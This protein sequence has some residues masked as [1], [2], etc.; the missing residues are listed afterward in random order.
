[1]LNGSEVGEGA[2]VGAGAIVTPRTK[3]PPFTMV[4]GVPAKVV[5]NLSE[6]EIENLKKHA[7]DY[8]ELMKKYK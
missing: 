4:L 6:E 3:I 1:V 2:I 8:V 7:L 5:R